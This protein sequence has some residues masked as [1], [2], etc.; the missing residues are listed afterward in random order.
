MQ[1][2]IAMYD[3][4]IEDIKFLA[5][6]KVEA[7][8]ARG[9]ANGELGDYRKAIA[10]ANQAIIVAPVTYVGYYSRGY[11]R[12]RWG[13]AEAERGNHAKSRTLYEKANK[14]L[15]GIASTGFKENYLLG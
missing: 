8:A 13:E 6:S 14:R 3:K 2:A 4:I 9:I 7:Y 1:G 12:I 15:H 10:D 11:T 5:I